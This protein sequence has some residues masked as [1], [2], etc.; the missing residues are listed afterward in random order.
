[1]ILL[2]YDIGDQALITVA[3]RLHAVC[4]CHFVSRF[5]TTEFAI[6]FVSDDVDDCQAL[7]ERILTIVVEPIYVEEHEISL[8]ISIGCTQVSDNRLS[9]DELV[10]QAN[11]ALHQAVQH[12]AEKIVSY[13]STLSQTL[14]DRVSMIKEL[15]LAIENKELVPYFQPQF[16]LQTNELVGA[17]VL[18]RWLKPDGTLIPP[19]QFIP[20]AEKSRLIIPIGRLVLN[21]ACRLNKLWQDQGLKPF[22]VAVNVSGVQFDEQ[23]IVEEVQQALQSSGLDAKWL[24]LEVTETALMSDIHEIVR[25]LTELRNLGLELAI[26][27]FGTGYSSLNYLKQL[28]IH[29]LKIDQS[30]VRNVINNEDDQ[31]II[32]TILN[33]GKTM[34]LKVLAEGVEGEAE[35]HYLKSLNCDEVQGFLLR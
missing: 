12:H 21:E 6:S 11:I 22:R 23:S 35:E 25:K 20:I 17:E 1:M 13:T 24:E 26:D 32:E 3:N 10:S 27:D 5:N 7:A 34:K 31:A 15:K 30:F 14:L 19:F 8:C 2:G 9:V 4:K 33:L 29:R 16:D 18:L 28:P